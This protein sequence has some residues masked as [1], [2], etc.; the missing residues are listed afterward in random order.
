MVNLELEFIGI[1]ILIAVTIV[2]NDIMEENLNK[3]Y[4]RK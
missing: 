4:E 1:R 3:S 2:G